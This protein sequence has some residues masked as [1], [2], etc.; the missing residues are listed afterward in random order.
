MK[1]IYL[2]LSLFIALTSF[3]QV[4]K[5]WVG[6]N[7]DDWTNAN[8][9]SPVNYPGTT[10]DV[11]FNTSAVVV[12]SI[13]IP[14]VNSITITNNAAVE[15]DASSKVRFGGTS[16]SSSSILA[17]PALT[18]DANCSFWLRGLTSVN[19]G[20]DFVLHRQSVINGSLLTTGGNSRLYLD[21][22]F[23][24]DKVTINGSYKA[25]TELVSGS[26]YDGG[27]IF[28]ASAGFGGLGAGAVVFGDNAIYE[29]ARSA[30]SPGIAPATWSPLSTLKITGAQSNGGISL[31]WSGAASHTIGNFV[32]DC[33][34]QGGAGNTGFFSSSLTPVATVQGD[35]IISNSNG[36]T[37]RF[38]SNNS[39]NQICTFK[40]N[41]TVSAANTLVEMFN[42]TAGSSS[43]TAIWNFEKNVSIASTLK[44]GSNSST[45]HILRFQ[46][47]AAGASGTGAQALSIAALADA[48][49]L[50]IIVN[51]A[52][53]GVV[54]GSDVGV[55]K[56]VTLTSGKILLGNFNLTAGGNGGAVNGS[57][58]TGWVVTDGNGSLTVKNIP[59][60]GGNLPV[61]I[62]DVSYDPVA[63]IPAVIDTFSVRVKNTF[64]NPVAD[65]S[66]VWNREWDI[67]SLN[68]T[69]ASIEF[70]PDATN[71]TPPS[72]TGT[73]VVG[74]Y[75]GGSWTETPSAG[76]G[77]FN[78][79]PYSASF[80]SYSPFAVGIQTGFTGGTA[81][82]I[83]E[84]IRGVKQASAH[85]INWKVNCLNTPSA[86][87][88]LERSTDGRTYSNEY[89]ISA[90]AERC[91]Q[92][93]SYSDVQPLPGL[94]Y[95]RLKMTDADGKVNY[96]SVVALLNKKTGFELINISP[97][98][99]KSNALL[100]ISAAEK[101]QLNLLVTDISGRQL[102][103]KSYQLIAGSNQLSINVAH[104]ARA[105]Y[106]LSAYTAGGEIKTIRFIKE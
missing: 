41:F 64:T 50:N 16:G 87:L 86:L 72:G 96:S 56:N 47:S 73:D 30:G 36:R 106:Q 15:F 9:W 88:N 60:T 90:T 10:D 22:S 17:A 93:F 49:A 12:I 26:Y 40:G 92:P 53:N 94:N 74:H 102:L 68:T 14:G 35:C 28:N 2:M 58:G 54:L 23:S 29:I 7:G 34:N 78:G 32:W 6:S 37:M 79:Y 98:V 81:P 19:N 83:I 48:G 39:T 76:A 18:V 38:S 31:S 77:A 57:G 85:T 67:V 13:D 75:I 20:V 103:S 99:V 24:N 105:V 101:M 97:N 25:G 95:Y 21:N 91:A 69:G 3:A 62:S 70:Q 43:G 89:T 44:L 66:K 46:G 33:P 100:N 55:L 59:V 61:G 45:T 42:S 51:N 71:A 63:V 65:P 8:A 4:T 82:V 5:T 52:G 1:K 84:Y 104:L 80:N 11:V 27:L